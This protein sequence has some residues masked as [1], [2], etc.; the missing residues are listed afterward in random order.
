MN[1]LNIRVRLGD[2][3]RY[4]TSAQL[5]AFASIYELDRIADGRYSSLFVLNLLLMSEIQGIDPAHVIVEL[6]A[7]E[8]KGPS[9]TKPETEFRGQHLQGLWHKHF[10]PPLPSA[11]AHNILNQLGKNGLSKIAEEVFGPHMGKTVT[12]EMLDEVTTRAIVDTITQRAD[13]NRL[14]GEW[15][16]FAREDGRNYYLGIWPHAQGDEEIAQSLRAACLPEF[17][18][19]QKYLS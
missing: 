9:F 2:Q 10:L 4:I 19:L 16:V 14:T 5:N 7:L 11:M 18:F 6:K 15:I 13:N 8:G 12:Q 17:P 1:D 3:T